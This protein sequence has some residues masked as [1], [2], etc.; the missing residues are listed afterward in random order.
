[1][2]N[3]EFWKPFYKFQFLSKQIYKI[4]VAYMYDYVSR[5]DYLG[6]LKKVIEPRFGSPL[7]IEYRNRI[8]SQNVC[9]STQEFYSIVQEINI[10]KKMEIIELG[11][12]YGRVAYIFLKTLPKVKY[13]IV[14]IPPALYVSQEYLRKIFP[15]EFFF[16]FRQFNNFK[17][18]EKDFLDA[19]IRFLLPHQIEYLPKDSFDIFVNISSF[20]EMRN[21]Q[22][23]NYIKQADRICKGFFYFKQWKKANAQDNNNIKENEYPIPAKWQKIYH[24][25]DPVHSSFFEALYET[26]SKKL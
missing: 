8:I 7:L 19:R 13:C 20:H 23:Q 26:R 5:I 17:E 22:I 18:I 15:K 10:A 6:I 3:K 1:M 9:N 24:H 11:A 2:E 25:T 4:Y 12:G 14:D 21:D 16:F